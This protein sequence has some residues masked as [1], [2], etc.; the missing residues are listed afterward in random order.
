MLNA[1][2]TDPIIA[3]LEVMMSTRQ[4]QLDFTQQVKDLKELIEAKEQEVEESKRAVE[5]SKSFPFTTYC[6]VG[7]Y[8]KATGRTLTVQMLASVAG[9]VT[10]VMNRCG[11]SPKYSDDPKF[12]SVAMY[13]EIL[14][15]MYLEDR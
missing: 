14:L 6:S 13:P 15:A 9:R 11:L 3:C 8:A 5:V 10:A 7:A 1:P 12:G 4:L 2:T